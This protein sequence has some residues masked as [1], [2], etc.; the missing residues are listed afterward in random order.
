MDACLTAGHEIIKII[1][2]HI[3][4]ASSSLRADI[5][6]IELRRAGLAVVPDITFDPGEGELYVIGEYGGET[7]YYFDGKGIDVAPLEL[8]RRDRLTSTV[9]RLDGAQVPRPG[10]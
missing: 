7:L 2:M 6:G 10:M 3:Q 9:R 4:K 5:P 8:G 1:S